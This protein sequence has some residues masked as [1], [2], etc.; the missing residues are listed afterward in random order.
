MA[1]GKNN[2]E[3][4]REFIKYRDNPNRKN[5]LSINGKYAEYRSMLLEEN[6]GLIKHISKRYACG[7]NDSYNNFDDIKHEGILGFF[8]ALDKFNP[9]LKYPLAGYSH[10]WIEQGI[11]RYLDEKSIIHIPA[12]VM[13]AIRG[14]L[15]KNK[16]HKNLESL[17]LNDIK[18]YK[19]QTEEISKRALYAL[20]FLNIISLNSPNQKFENE[21]EGTLLDCIGE[22]EIKKEDYMFINKCLGSLKGNH[23][24][25]ILEKYF[26]DKN[27]REIGE[28]MNLSRERIR[29]IEEKAI[30]IMKLSLIKSEPAYCYN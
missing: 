22:K 23:K 13:T 21:E 28:E 3:L 4:M 7:T 8:R 25:V 10:Y 2:R 26:H 18:K 30:K 5:N 16:N 19:N 29:Q 12:S 11:R 9:K 14:T 27:L 1:S 6:I 15:N 20:R 24:K 17:T